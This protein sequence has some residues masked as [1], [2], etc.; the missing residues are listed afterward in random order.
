MHPDNFEVRYVGITNRPKAR[1]SSHCNFE[2]NP[3]FCSPKD[4]WIYGLSVYGLSPKMVVIAEFDNR[5]L[6]ER[7][8]YLLV[9]KLI[10]KGYNILNV[11]TAMSK[12]DGSKTL[13][14]TYTNFIIS[15]RNLGKL[16]HKAG[17]Y[18]I[19]ESFSLS[20]I[21]STDTASHIIRLHKSDMLKLEKLS[22]YN[23]RTLSNMIHKI[24]Y[25]AIK[26]VKLEAN[27]E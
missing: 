21:K 17:V 14:Q 1:L 23:M 13:A 10:N 24:I 5:K 18:Y 16:F 25:D 27:N 4:E 15:K 8:E 12:F 7:D 3:G 11:L 22:K 26:D 19:N 9:I 2:F 6:A 20:N